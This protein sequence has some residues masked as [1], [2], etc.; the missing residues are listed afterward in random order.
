MD[1]DKKAW[2]KVRG[3]FHYPAVQEP[4]FV[5]HYDG[6]ACYDFKKNAVLVDANFI[7]RVSQKSGLQVDRCLEGVYAHEIGHYMVFPR[8]LA[9]LLLAAYMIDN[10]FPKDRPGKDAVPDDPKSEP[11]KPGL[12]P[13]DKD[14]KE[15]REFILQT[16]MDMAN[17]TAAVLQEQ[18]TSA[19]MDMRNAI[20]TDLDDEL[21]RNIRSVMLAYLHHQA[22]RPYELAGELKPY[23][24]KMKEVDF[25]NV[26]HEKMRQGLFTFG[27]IIMDMMKKYPP[28]GGGLSIGIGVPKDGDVDGILK[29]TT[30]SEIRDAL[31]GISYKLTKG[32]RERLVKW[33]K[34]K[35]VDMPGTPISGPKSI[36]TSE[37]VI[38][39]DP[40]VVDYYLELSREYPIVTTKKLLDTEGKARAWSETERWRPGTDSG[41]ALPGSSGGLLLPG[42]TRK[43][44]ITE[45]PIQTVDYKVPHLLVILD[46][47][48]SMPD[49]KQQKSFAVLA[50]FC[51]ARSY[52]QQ[53]AHIGVINFS[54]SSFY[55]PYT[56]D[57]YDALGAISAY[58]GGGTVA[59]VDMIRKMLGPEAAKLY[60]EVPE[61]DLRHL[62]R[63]FLR[64]E[65]SISM[66][67]LYHAF[68]AKSIDVVL[69]TDGGIANLNEVLQLFEEKA[70]LNRATIVLTDGFTQELD[71]YQGKVKVH[72]VKNDADIPHIV[73]S[74]TSKGF[75]SFSDKLLI[76]G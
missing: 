20:Q 13:K 70:E 56:R 36:G 10:M 33:L 39:V 59:D 38:T 42:I 52:H 6:G 29:G 15:V 37:G 22:A 40:E 31:R 16:Y 68:E 14:N 75:N 12:F 76:G 18:R 27:H 74:E 45:R 9:T 21:N 28:Q 69:F 5:A 73:I 63:Q 24:E 51:V 26:N 30:P 44:K 3:W 47:S 4:R 67:H 72:R 11:G 60:G 23:F 50:G 64:K 58:Q 34:D 25:L 71:E 43:V 32:E 35:G 46:S 66:E 2:N 49:P 53:E 1:D 65:V 7:E 19:I 57:L 17:D 48:G 62:R 8:D 41:L 61:R 55:L 54:G